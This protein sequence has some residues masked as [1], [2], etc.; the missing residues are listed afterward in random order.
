MEKLILLDDD[1]LRRRTI[2][3]IKTLGVDEAVDTQE[4]QMAASALKLKGSTP[5]KLD[6]A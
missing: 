2:E 6:E 3:L 5:F 4:L 1:A